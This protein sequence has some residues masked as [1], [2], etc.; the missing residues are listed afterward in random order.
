MFL[1]RHPGYVRNFERTLAELARRGHEVQVVFERTTTKWLGDQNPLDDLRANHPTI[2]QCAAPRRK[3]TGWNRIARDLRISLDYLRYLAPEYA[4]AHKLRDRAESRTPW[5]V[6]AFGRS[7][8]GRSAALRRLLAGFL[9]PLEA[10][11]PLDPSLDRFLADQSPDRLL[12]TPLVGI[13]SD[14]IDYVR[15]AHR[16]RVPTALCVASWDNLTNK[17]LIREAP[18]L[19]AVWNEGQRREAIELHGIPEDRVIATG[20]HTYDHWFEWSPG[21][22]RE[23]FLARVDLDPERPMLLYLC[24][25]PFIAPEETSFVRDWIEN[26]R[27]AGGRLAETGILIRPHPQN[28]AQWADVDVS[29][30]PGV[31]IWPRA[32]ADPV[33]HSAKSDFYDS[34]HYCEAV[35][36]VNTSALIET[37]IV[38]RTVFTILDER[39][40]ETQE[41]TLH[42]GHLV[43]GDAG[44][45]T[46]AHS[47]DEH[48]AQLGRL[49]D[50]AVE[51]T[52]S[53]FLQRFVRPQGLEL[54]SAPLL[55][56]TIEQLTSTNAVQPRS[57][58]VNAAI[59][60]LLTPAAL[61]LHPGRRSQVVHAARR[62]RRL[63]RRVVRLVRRMLRP[64]RRMLRPLRRM[65]R[66]VP[67][68]VRRVPRVLRR[69][70]R[71][72][73]RF[74]RARLG[75]T[76]PGDGEGAG[77]R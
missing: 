17:G 23:E 60:V 33:T 25:S 5:L 2:S 11:L 30:S 20:A 54:S 35:V 13:G 61:A 70:A 47:F 52:N 26:V 72:L 74:I 16:R 43:D 41:G 64:L 44:L 18:D 21:T 15:A 46:V 4:R 3:K 69:L 58:T 77:Q 1:M 10:A 67:R 14:Q 50:T 7:T 8:L 12:V 36:G 68:L 71:P 56:D 40:R 73:A 37:A 22:S 38:G 75:A 19:V 39:F 28:A 63:P 51:S 59:R 49:L 76:P 6:R 27:G 34:I 29:A 24:S 57:G 65:L 45:L 53:A 42:F 55:A 66:R 9:R 32:G 62:A 31:Q 48:V